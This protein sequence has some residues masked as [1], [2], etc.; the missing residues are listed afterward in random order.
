MRDISPYLDVLFTTIF[1]LMNARYLTQH[2]IH[3]VNLTFK[4]SFKTEVDFF[5]SFEYLEHETGGPTWSCEAY[6]TKGWLVCFCYVLCDV[7]RGAVVFFR[8]KTQRVTNLLRKEHCRTA[9]MRTDI[10]LGARYNGFHKKKLLMLFI[11]MHQKYNTMS[12]KILYINKK[13]KPFW[14]HDIFLLFTKRSQSGWTILCL[15]H[16]AERVCLCMW[17]SI[18]IS[19]FPFQPCCLRD[20]NDIPQ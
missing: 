8:V 18:W 7:M 5:P 3:T 11:C 4:P 20:Q 14:H 1:L 2:T 9:T 19:G 15:H 13:I 12:N 17:K 16:K 6:S 10:P